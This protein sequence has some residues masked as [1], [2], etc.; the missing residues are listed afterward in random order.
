MSNPIDL[1]FAALASNYLLKEYQIGKIYGTIQ[2]AINKKVPSLELVQGQELNLLQKRNQTLDSNLKRLGSL[3]KYSP[4]E[5]LA[6]I[7]DDFPKEDG[8]TVR[9]LIIT[10]N[11]IEIKGYYVKHA[12]LR[13]IERA[14]NLK[15]R[16]DIY[17]EVDRKISG[18]S[19]KSFTFSIKICE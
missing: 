10:P 9:D 5:S 2:E 3:S 12:A 7:S 8:I 15:R 6:R 18:S 11:K 13:T 19:T 17:C 14:L 4:L 1:V 16:K